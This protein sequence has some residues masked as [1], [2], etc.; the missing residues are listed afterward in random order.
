MRLHLTA[1]AK[2]SI[3]GVNSAEA[4]KGLHKP[5]II[6]AKRRMLGVISKLK[7]ADRNYLCGGHFTSKCVSIWAPVGCKYDGHYSTADARRRLGDGS[8]SKWTCYPDYS[9][10]RSNGRPGI[11]DLSGILRRHVRAECVEE[12][13]GPP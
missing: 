5:L 1:L 9:I 4:S 6:S 7:L 3:Q 11:R 12:V 10:S 2:D 8:L 13:S